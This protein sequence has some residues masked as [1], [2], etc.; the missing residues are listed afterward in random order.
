MPAT[1]ALVL[2]VVKLILDKRIAIW[3]AGVVILTFL[4]ALFQ[5]FRCNVPPVATIVSGILE[6][7]VV[8]VEVNHA[9]AVF[10]ENVVLS[11]H[12]LLFS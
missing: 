7:M 2:I 12:S 4:Y 8:L 1:S 6:I 3:T 5:L 11:G 9:L 10:A